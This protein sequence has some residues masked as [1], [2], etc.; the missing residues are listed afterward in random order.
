MGS[1]TEVSYGQPLFC[2]CTVVAGKYLQPHALAGRARAAR[3]ETSR[4]HCIRIID[5][6]K[7]PVSFKT[8]LS[9][10]R[11]CSDRMRGQVVH[12]RQD[13]GLPGG[14]AAAAPR[15]R[16]RGGAHLPGAR[17]A[18]G[19]GRRVRPA[20]ARLRRADR[21]AGALSLAGVSRHGQQT[22]HAPRRTHLPVHECVCMR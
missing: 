2:I 4:Q 20:A 9:N 7:N 17:Y 22:M 10:F 8:L 11:L 6:L 1:K 19:L 12:G 18:E 21:G 15:G 3:R 13:R 16:A 5:W 14:S